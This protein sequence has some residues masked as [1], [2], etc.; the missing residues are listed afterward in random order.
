MQ[1]WRKKWKRGKN[2]SVKWRSNSPRSKRRKR[3]GKKRWRCLWWTSPNPLKCKRSKSETTARSPLT[4]RWRW[5]R[6]TSSSKPPNKNS[7]KRCHCRMIWSAS[8]QR[9]RRSLRKLEQSLSKAR[10][11]PK[12]AKT[13]SF[14]RRI[15]SLRLSCRWKQ[16]VWT[17][18]ASQPTKSTGW[19]S[20]WIRAQKC[21]PLQRTIK[22]RLSP[23]SQKNWIIPSSNSIK[24]SKPKHSRRPALTWSFKS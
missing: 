24:H 5:V 15:S 21:S 6:R 7:Q 16:K 14:G 17:C 12:P 11:K 9:W 8:W 1:S 10:V 2:S 13:S 20:C 4:I 19:P 18:K 3:K 23:I 22:Q